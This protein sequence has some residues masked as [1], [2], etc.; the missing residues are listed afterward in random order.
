MDSPDSKRESVNRKYPQLPN[1]K[2]FNNQTSNGKGMLPIFWKSLEPILERVNNKQCSIEVYDSEQTERTGVE[3][4]FVHNKPAWT[5]VLSN[6][7]VE[8]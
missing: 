6:R 8:P 4:R 3:G 7:N 5:P 1:R 2:K